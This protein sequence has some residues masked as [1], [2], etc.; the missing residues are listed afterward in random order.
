LCVTQRQHVQIGNQTSGSH[1]VFILQV[2]WRWMR[3]SVGCLPL[4]LKHTYR[5]QAAH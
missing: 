1:G 3:K 4:G 2:L 5:S